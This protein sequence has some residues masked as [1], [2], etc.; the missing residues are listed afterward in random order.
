VQ[1]CFISVVIPGCCPSSIDRG[2]IEQFA[3]GICTIST[4][5]ETPLPYGELPIPGIHYIQ[6]A[7]DFSD[8]RN[9]I[10]WAYTH[11]DECVQIGKNAS[12][13]FWACYEPVKY[14]QWIEQVMLNKI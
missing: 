11:K 9:V 3:L 5:L 6:C 8:L 13:L 14:F 2:H 10:H 4:Y 1:D 7:G 12:Q